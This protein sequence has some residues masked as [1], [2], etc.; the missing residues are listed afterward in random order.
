MMKLIKKIGISL[1][2]ALLALS[3]LLSTFNYTQI[4]QAAKK[5]TKKSERK[6][7][8]ITDAP[9]FNKFGH[10][11]K[12]NPKNANTDYDS[13]V[14]GYRYVDDETALP[15][16]G[17]R[18]INGQKYYHLGKGNYVN[19]AYV[20]TVNGKNTKIGKLVLSHKSLI[21]TKSGKSQKRTLATNSVVKYQGEVKESKTKP[22]FYYSKYFKSDNQEH[23]YYLPTV[24]IKN[25]NYFSLGKNRY[26]LANNVGSIDGYILIYNGVTYATVLQKTNTQT[27]SNNRT[28]HTLNKGQRIK[29]DLAV[30]PWAEDFEGYIY[31]LHDYPDEYVDGSFIKLRNYLP[32]INYDDL[33]YSFV[34]PKST[35][36]TKLYDFSGVPTGINLKTSQQSKLKVDGLIYLW[37]PSEK[38]AELFY[39]F[40]NPGPY[41]ENYVND[42]GTKIKQPAL[43]PKTNKLLITTEQKLVAIKSFIKASD[44]EFD[45]GVKLKP[46][47]T[48][49]EAE[50]DQQVATTA[51]KEAFQKL[52]EKEKEYGFDYD[53]GRKL[54][55]ENYDTALINE[56][57]VLT[58]SKATIAELKLAAWLVETTR[59]Q[60]TTLDFE[61]WS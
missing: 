57:N 7:T 33:A 51:D 25:K 26:I 29:V 37:V 4:V 35:E 38:K 34:K 39:H 52:F 5:E 21:Y 53:Y 44:V 42:D 36:N 10:K 43:D 16:Y 6:V 23:F 32:T 31:R 40:L 56:S 9:I 27:I 12:N 2:A 41:Y 46:I 48:P 13:D 49:E 8:L 50:H 30:I 11:I 60:I 15:Y 47:N 3:P 54:L 45:G 24:K 61:D 1:T 19:D 58:S 28:K 55:L 18:E 20:K 14:N 59:K 17:A 22:T